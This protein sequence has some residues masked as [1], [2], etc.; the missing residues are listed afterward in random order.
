MLPSGVFA[1]LRNRSAKRLKSGK[2][3]GVLVSAATRVTA[4]PLA[5]A[6]QAGLL[7]FEALG[8]LDQHLDEIRDR[9]ARGADVRHEQHGVAAGLVDLDPVLVHQVG[10]LEGVA[11]DARARDLDRDTARVDHELVLRPGLPHPWAN[12]SRSGIGRPCPP[13]LLRGSGHRALSTRKYFFSK[14]CLATAWAMLTARSAC[15][16]TS[17]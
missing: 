3:G 1:S 15:R 10:V 6:A 4:G 9:A 2:G 8:Q 12:P 11:V 13:V 16:C 14:G 5:K 7:V 17:S